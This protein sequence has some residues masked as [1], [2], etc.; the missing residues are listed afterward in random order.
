[1]TDVLKLKDGKSAR[2]RDDITF[3]DLIREYMGDDSAQY[4]EDRITELDEIAEKL[5]ELSDFYHNTIET[6][7]E[8]QEDIKKLG[9]GG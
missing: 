6:V 2:V 9:W 8:I 4:Y 5:D 1:M 3:Q 7:R